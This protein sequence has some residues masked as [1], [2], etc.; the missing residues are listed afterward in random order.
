M[1]VL[2]HLLND[3]LREAIS[4]R[5]KTGIFDG[6]MF[7]SV[8]HILAQQYTQVFLALRESVV[9]VIPLRHPA[10][11]RDS[12]STCLFRSTATDTQRTTLSAARC[13]SNDADSI[14]HEGP[15]HG[16]TPKLLIVLLEPKKSRGTTKKISGALRQMGAPH[17]FKFRSAATLRW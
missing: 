14:G 15:G 16:G 9:T 1:S 3:T 6:H 10:R 13:G 2:G 5:F 7:L 4:T 11:T 8:L 12:D 17:T